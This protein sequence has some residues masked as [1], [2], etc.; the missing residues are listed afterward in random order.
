MGAGEGIRRGGTCPVPSARRAGRRIAA[1]GIGYSLRM[2]RFGAAALLLVLLTV[3]AAPSR[4]APP[5]SPAAA[6]PYDRVLDEHRA[7]LKTDVVVRAVDAVRLLDPD[8]PRSMPEYMGILARWH[9]RVRGAAMEA[10]A[11][12]KAPALRAEMRLH[13]VTHDDPWV[14]EGMAFAMTITPVAGDGE[15]LVLAMDDKDARVRRTAARG[16]GE[17]VSREGV[18]RLVKTYEDETDL[19]VRVWAR[20]SLRSIV[21]DDLGFDPKPWRAWWD[22]NKDRPEFKPHP[23]EVRRS[24]FKGVPLERITI[25]V[26]PGTDDEKAARSKRPDLFVLA[27]FGWS[28]AW[29]RPYLDEAARFLRITYVTLPTV[30]EVTG[31][32]G[33]GQSI[34]V[35]PVER[36]AKAIDL[37]REEQGKDQVMILATGPVGWIAETYAMRF[38]KHVAGMVIADSWLDAQAYGESLGRTLRDGSPYERWAAQTLTSAGNRDQSEERELRSVWLTSSLGDKRDSEAY[39]LWRTA[40]RD[41]GFATVPPLQFDRHT[42]VSTPTLFMFPDPEIQPSSGGTSEDLR[43]I[44]ASFKDPTPVTAILRD[45]RGFLLQEDPAEFL[46][47]LRGFLDFVGVTR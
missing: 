3:S 34:P 32:S 43:R 18:A 12:V 8:N 29:F 1:D 21:G 9:W 28:H 38:P 37:L 27:P 13:L 15:A 47:V 20:S 17:I 40:A 33:Y 25:D 22:R 45:S 11:A 19:R 42:K 26:P 39:R 6:D 44:R 10:L 36:L 16:L 31:S 5:D 14:R 46:R 24:D 7:K 30:P 4:A 41:H 2:R 23:D 35:Y